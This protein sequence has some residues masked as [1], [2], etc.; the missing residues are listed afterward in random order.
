MCHARSHVST[1]VCGRCGGRKPEADF[2]LSRTGRRLAPTCWVCRYVAA[3]T[4]RGRLAALPRGPFGSRPIRLDPAE[5]PVT[6]ACRTCGREKPL[7]EFYLF[8]S[9]GRRHCRCRPCTRAAMR[10]YY[11]ANRAKV[12]A[13]QRRWR[14]QEDPEQRLARVHRTR[15]RH[16]REQA[17]RD[18]TYRLR[19]LGVLDLAENCEDCGGPARDIHHEVYGDVLSLV[20]LC[21]RC[22]MARH[23]RRW[24]RHG[25]GPVRYPEEYEQEM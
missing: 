25:G 11:A 1:M 12:V 9:T 3:R 6:R 2:R 20:S 4:A 22:H 23:F 17:V 8:R 14:A 24:R 15:S 16:P 7:A 10:R 5:P 13:A 21:R 19:V 18:R